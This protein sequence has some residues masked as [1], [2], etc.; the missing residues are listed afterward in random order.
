MLL[1][2]YSSVTAG[3]DSHFNASTPVQTGLIM[4]PAFDAIGIQ[5]ESRGVALGNNPC[6]PYDAC[7][8]FFCGDDADVVHWE[9]TYFC[10]D[11]R[12]I[13]E[14]FIRQASFM[15][16]QPVVVFSDSHSGKWYSSCYV[17]NG[18]VVLWLLNNLCLH[19]QGRGTV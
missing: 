2:S 12:P 9:Q 19:Y 17:L 4:K 3:H 16:S 14:Q 10:A 7:V 6:T 8:K 13:I 1:L 11:N 5:L 15:K 18:Y